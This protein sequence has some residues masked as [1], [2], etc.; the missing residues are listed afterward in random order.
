M[1][2][3]KP[4]KKNGKVEDITPKGRGEDYNLLRNKGKKLELQKKRRDPY[5]NFE[6]R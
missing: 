3:K 2:E 5:Q 1:G 4:G 6:R